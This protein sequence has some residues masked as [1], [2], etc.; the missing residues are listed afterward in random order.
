VVKIHNGI[1]VSHKEEDDAEK[2]LEAEIT[3]M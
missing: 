2:W 1:L 3:A